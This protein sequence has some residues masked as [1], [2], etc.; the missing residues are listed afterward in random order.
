MASKISNQ[1]DDTSI[2]GKFFELF[3]ELLYQFILNNEI[4]KEQFLLDLFDAMVKALNYNYE[5][6]SSKMFYKFFLIN[7]LYPI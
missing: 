6:N 7:Y 1:M 4:Y 3:F 2:I 5:K